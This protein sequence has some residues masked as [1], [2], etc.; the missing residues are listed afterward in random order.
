[1]PGVDD[2]EL[3]RLFTCPFRYEPHPLCV[4]AAGEVRR[5]L[6]SLSAR[7]TELDKGKMFGVLVVQKDGISGFLAAYSGLL[8][9]RNDHGFF[10]PPV[11]DLLRPDG[12]FKAE[13]ARISEM[14][15]RV[16]FLEHSGKRASLLRLSTDMKAVGGQALAR[17]RE[18]LRD[19]KRQR[20]LMR[21]SDPGVLTDERLADESR[22]LKAEYKRMERQWKA[23]IEEAENAL[24]RWDEEI[25][26]LKAER[27]RRS[28]L[29][30]NRIFS[31]FRMLNARGEEKD[32]WQIFREHGHPVP[33]SG[34][35]E[36]AAPKLLQYAYRN[37]FR[38]LAMAE[39]RWEDSPEE[40]RREHDR[41][42]PAC[43]NKCGPI[44]DHMLQGLDIEPGAY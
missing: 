40:E 31:Q 39:F 35:G 41:Y 13:E 30:Q 17:A 19:A 2:D 43:K 29:L 14:N 11:F 1:M 7:G 23:R 42:Y 20:D 32:L 21:F 33:P 5:H 10:V 25:D 16:D 3:P 12:F 37:G 4:R 27:K 26:A 36:C 24:K 22:F 8:C 28:A 6:A 34:A 9:G 15:H 44:L 38:P 18:A